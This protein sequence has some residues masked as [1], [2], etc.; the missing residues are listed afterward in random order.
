MGRKSHQ[1][2][3]HVSDQKYRSVKTVPK[4]EQKPMVAEA[5]MPHTMTDAISSVD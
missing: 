5:T 3:G 2:S 4:L 1:R